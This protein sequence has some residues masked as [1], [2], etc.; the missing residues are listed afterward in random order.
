MSEQYFSL[1]IISRNS[2]FQSYPLHHARKRILQWT[3]RRGASP[4]QAG[5]H[6]EIEE[7]NRWR[8]SK[9]R[10]SRHEFDLGLGLVGREHARPTREMITK[11]FNWL[12]KC[13]HGNIRM[14]IWYCTLSMS[15]CCILNIH[16][17][18]MKYSKRMF[19][20]LYLH[21]Y[22]Y[23]FLALLHENFYFPLVTAR[24]PYCLMEEAIVMKEKHI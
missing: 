6:T 21:W 9:G 13:L 18:P 2:I 17:T 15:L 8:E 14:T 5:S 16:N 20:I 11:M 10:S 19:I 4:A 3:S 23:S 12:D 22:C 7:M 1:T 24:R